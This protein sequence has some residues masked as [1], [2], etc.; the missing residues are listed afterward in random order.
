MKIRKEDHLFRGENQLTRLHAVL[1]WVIMHGR[2]RDIIEEN[3]VGKLQK[4]GLPCDAI[5]GQESLQEEILAMCVCILGPPEIS[6]GE[7]IWK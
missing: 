1:F 5:T 2:I 4:C 6:Y 3:F 7:E